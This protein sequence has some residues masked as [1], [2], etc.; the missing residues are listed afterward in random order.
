[1]VGF[2]AA[3]SSITQIQE[4]GTTKKLADMLSRPPMKKIAVVG[5]IMAA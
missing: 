3:I 1:M 4:G 5:V 2:L